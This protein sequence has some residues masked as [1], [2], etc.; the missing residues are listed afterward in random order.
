MAT[1]ASAR[2]SSDKGTD[3]L[4]RQRESLAASIPSTYAHHV[5]SLLFSTGTGGAAVREVGDLGA[6]KGSIVGVEICNRSA[7]E[8]HVV[9]YATPPSGNLSM[10]NLP[11]ACVIIPLCTEAVAGQ[12][13]TRIVR[14]QFATEQSFRYVAFVAGNGGSNAATNAW[15][16]LLSSDSTLTTDSYTAAANVGDV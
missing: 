5:P 7:G 15:V 16:S 12:P 10:T 6:A 9:L 4:E 11:A 2:F 14:R 3:L 8:A 13:A 1:P